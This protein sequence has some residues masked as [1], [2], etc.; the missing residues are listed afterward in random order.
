MKITSTQRRALQFFRQHQFVDLMVWQQ[1]RF[2][3]LSCL[4]LCIFAAAGL[5]FLL[6]TGSGTGWLWVG[7]ATGALVRDIGRFRALARLW[8]LYREITDWKR[9]ADLLEPDSEVP[10]SRNSQVPP[11]S[12]T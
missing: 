10:L 5:A 11:G 1:I 3:W 4:L 2:N 6:L 12:S 7:L 8:P 9:V